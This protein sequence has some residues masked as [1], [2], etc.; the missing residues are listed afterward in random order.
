MLEDDGGE[1]LSRD[2]LPWLENA[3]AWRRHLRPMQAAATAPKDAWQIADLML[4]R[5]ELGGFVL[6]LGEWLRQRMF[7]V[8]FASAGVAVVESLSDIDVLALRIKAVLLLATVADGRSLRV[9]LL[10]GNPRSA[11]LDRG[12]SCGPPTVLKISR[13][14]ENHELDELPVVSVS[15]DVMEHALRSAI[16]SQAAALGS[17][18]SDN[19]ER[20]IAAVYLSNTEAAPAVQRALFKLTESFGWS[21]TPD[22][23]PM[24]GSFFRRF[25]LAAINFL[26]SEPAK[27][28]A[29]EVRR[30]V[31]LATIH[32][33]QADNDSKQAEAV[34]NLLQA[35]EGTEQAVL[36][37]GSVLILKGDGKV[38]ARTL[39]QRQLAFLE[40]HPISVTDPAAV[41]F[42]LDEC[43]RS[44]PEETL[45]PARSFSAI[46]V[47]P[48]A[49]LTDGDSFTA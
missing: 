3:P 22:S 1:D 47:F 25:K 19:P 33:R 30:G 49:E 11:V 48:S 45:P 35:L 5:R 12:C 42:A 24:H 23:D 4:E 13:A 27:E 18:N 46:T 31:E 44:I 7:T 28:I 37:V 21:A 40:R 32:S 39:T 38:S 34:T 41:L 6:E 10:R 15:H 29:L 26:T 8:A 43:A 20:Q 36:L 17:A 2:L 14:I 16:G 9:R